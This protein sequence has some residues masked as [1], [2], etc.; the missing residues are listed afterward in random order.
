MSSELKS[1]SRARFRPMSSGSRAIGPP[2]A[3]IPTPTSHC[4]MMAFSQLAK[5]MSQASASS[6][7][8]PVARPRMRAMEANGARVRRTRKSG[9][10]G[11]ACGT[12]RHC[13]EVLDPR[14]EIGVIQEVVV[15]GAVEDHD[16]DMLVGIE[17]VP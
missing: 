15:D 12:G 16:P 5:L 3:T 4:E 1:T 17:S 6:L 7:P 2:P 9:Q 14:H 11:Q 8:L 10:R 13:G